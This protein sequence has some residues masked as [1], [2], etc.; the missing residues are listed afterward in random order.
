MRI[1]SLYQHPHTTAVT[2]VKPGGQLHGASGGG[3]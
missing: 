3:G 1:P 2:M